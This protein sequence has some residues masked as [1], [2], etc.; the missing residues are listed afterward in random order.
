MKIMT[1]SDQV[2][3]GYRTEVVNWAKTAV[4]IV[5]L[6]TM[7]Y[8]QGAASE[9]GEQYAPLIAATSSLATLA[10]AF[11]NDRFSGARTK[12]IQELGG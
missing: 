6:L 5:G 3:T 10:L 7:A 11:L 12:R 4:A 1:F 9:W 2:S 8:L